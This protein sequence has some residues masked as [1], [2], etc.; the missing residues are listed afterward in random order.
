MRPNLPPM[1]QFCDRHIL[2]GTHVLSP[3]IGYE[4]HLPDPIQLFGATVDELPDDLLAL[5]NSRPSTPIATPSSE[6][7]T[8]IFGRNLQNLLNIVR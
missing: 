8:R 5:V 4:I 7:T 3:F 6:Y 2:G 1:S